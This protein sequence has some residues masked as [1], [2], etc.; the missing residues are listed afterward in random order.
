M[1]P[2]ADILAEIIKTAPEKAAALAIPEPLQHKP[3]QLALMK[4][5]QKQVVWAEGQIDSL[6]S[7]FKL[8]SSCTPGCSACCRQ[9]IWAARAE[10]DIIKAYLNNQPAET[11]KNILEQ[12]SRQAEILLDEFGTVT[13]GPM[14]FNA[15]ETRQ[16]YFALNL[17]CPLLNDEGLCAIYPVRPSNCWAFRS[18]GPPEECQNNMAPPCAI[19]YRDIERLVVVDNLYKAKK[20]RSDNTLLP[21]ALLQALKP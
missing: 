7:D 5:Y 14:T 3:N 6:E 16:R 20:P 4:W 13:M 1:Y 17:K 9:M 18:Y 15:P 8:K 2:G 10:V 21:A 11:V 19:H 12:C